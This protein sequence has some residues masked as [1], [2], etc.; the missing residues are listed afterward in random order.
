MAGFSLLPRAGR[1]KLCV[2][3][4][5]RYLGA[6]DIEGV[7]RFHKGTARVLLDSYHLMT[8][9]LP[10]TF[11]P[12]S[13]RHAA[14][15]PQTGIT[16][17]ASWPLVP[18]TPEPAVD[19]FQISLAKGTKVTFHIVP[20]AP[21]SA[22]PSSTFP[23]QLSSEPHHKSYSNRNLHKTTCFQRWEVYQEIKFSGDC[24]VL[25]KQNGSPGTCEVTSYAPF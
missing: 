19:R 1:F 23:Q 25:P 15:S 9:Q 21:I 17:P 2:R 4:I 8:D 20:P 16:R 11:A 7:G 24:L 22:P 13:Q 14:R 10:C 12:N 3:S 5:E 6:S 18:V